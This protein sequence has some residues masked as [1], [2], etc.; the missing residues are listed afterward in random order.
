M[1]SP[2]A[3]QTTLTIRLLGGFEVQLGEATVDDSAW[4]GRKAQQL[5]KLLAVTPGRSMHRE[6]IADALWPD[7][8]GDSADRQLHKAIHAARRALDPE[9]TSGADSCWILT[10][11]RTVRLSPR[12]KIDADQ[13]EAAAEA[14]LAAKDAMACNAA[15]ASFRGTLL[16][17]DLYDSWSEPRRTR[18]TALRSRLLAV[19]AEDGVATGQ[20]ERAAEAANALLSLDGADER[21]HRVLMRVAAASGDRAAVVR[22][23]RACEAALDAEL[24]V[25]PSE[26]TRSLFE[27]LLERSSCPDSEIAPEADRSGN[28]GSDASESVESPRLDA[29]PAAASRERDSGARRESRP[30]PGWIGVAGVAAALL[31]AAVLAVVFGVPGIRR[32]LSTSPTAAPVTTVTGTL[33]ASFVRVSMRPSASKWSSFTNSDGRFVL[34]DVGLREGETVTIV[35]EGGD[36]RRTAVSSIVPAPDASG[37]SDLGVLDASAL[38]PIDE[39]SGTDAFVRQPFDRPNLDWYRG[40]AAALTA[41]LPTDRARVSAIHD[42]VAGRYGRPADNGPT[43]NARRTIEAGTLYSGPLPVAM[44]TLTQALEYPTR[45]VTVSDAQPGGPEHTVVEVFYDGRWHLFDPAF[46]VVAL[47]DVGEIANLEDIARDPAL[48]DR[49]PYAAAVRPG[50]AG[51]EIPGLLRSGVYR[52]TL[53]VDEPAVR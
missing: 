53:L 8:D 52:V 29:N 40:A 44:A 15:L 2:E 48:V 45:L 36:G 28:T 37:T 18:L 38:K 6:Q 35:A 9:L 42:F 34:R 30:R 25:A 21:A 17:A 26:V 31:L 33:P 10:Q 16:P 19:V 12:V 51:S 3:V 13:A 50:W 4:R 27:S 20:P 14:A 41:G 32:A 47:N 22:Q 11:D 1:S 39:T 43:D 46:G 7:L 24:G 5:V 49:M 23:F